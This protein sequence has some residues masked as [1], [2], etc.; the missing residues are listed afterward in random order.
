MLAFAIVASIAQSNPAS[1]KAFAE[2]HSVKQKQHQ[3]NDVD[4]EAE[5]LDIDPGASLRKRNAVTLKLRSDF[6]SLR[7]LM[8]GIYNDHLICRYCEHGEQVVQV[9]LLVDG[10][11]PQA[12][13]L[14]EEANKMHLVELWDSVLQVIDDIEVIWRPVKL[15]AK[16]VRLFF[17]CGVFRKQVLLTFILDCTD[18]VINDLELGLCD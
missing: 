18:G 10:G 11:D 9:R 7:Q 2:L 6:L 1:L 16:R 5:Y 8:V 15:R 12:D 4:E 14:K 17:D 13:Q 3:L